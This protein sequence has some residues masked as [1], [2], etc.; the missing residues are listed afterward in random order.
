MNG[1]KTCIRNIIL[2]SIMGQKSWWIPH[3]EPNQSIASGYSRKNTDEM[4]HLTRTKKGL[5]KKDFHKKRL[6][7]MRRI[8]PPH[9]NGLPFVFYFP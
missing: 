3:L 2:S 9:Q 8:F 7:I 5:R 6:L 1:K 4:D